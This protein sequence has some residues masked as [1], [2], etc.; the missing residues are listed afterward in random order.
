MLKSIVT[1]GLLFVLPTSSGIY[2]SEN[3]N[4]SNQVTITSCSD[5][6]S[7]VNYKGLDKWIINSTYDYDELFRKYINQINYYAN[8]DDDD[9]LVDFINQINNLDFFNSFINKFYSVSTVET[10]FKF[11]N[12]LLSSNINIFTS[13]YKQGLSKCIDSNNISIKKKALNIDSLYKKY[14]EE[15]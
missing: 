14:F 7:Q 6:F 9:K 8:N 13:W 2:Q 5:S 10:I 4:H 1:A 11:L 15:N 3:F 12:I